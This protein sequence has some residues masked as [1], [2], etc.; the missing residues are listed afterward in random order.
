MSMEANEL[1][2]TRTPHRTRRPRAARA[3]DLCRAKKN[4]CDESY[5]C[6]Y[7]KNRNATCV[8]QGSQHTSWR[9]TAEYV[10]QLEDEVKRLSTTP[11][12]VPNV[13]SLVRFEQSPTGMDIDIAQHQTD[14]GPQPDTFVAAQGTSEE[15]ISEVNE[16]TA[17]VEF[18]GSSS[19]IALLSRVQRSGQ[20]SGDKEDGTHLVSNLH[21][22]TFQT[23]PVASHGD[24]PGAGSS[25][26]DYYPQC[27]SFIETFFSTIHY[28]HPILDKCEF[29]ER[30]E[31]LWSS[32]MN[33]ASLQVSGSFIALY[34]G[35]LSLGAIVSV[36]GEDPIDG[37]T[38]L[39]WSRKFFDLS[40]TCCHSLGLITNLEIAQC[41][42]VLVCT[43][44]GYYS[45]MLNPYSGKSLPERTKPTL[46]ERRPIN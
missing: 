29:L 19:S 9:Y 45:I 24:T 25:R 2:P 27:R 11:T 38:N 13:Q 32:S 6:T 22:A 30:C 10:K 4:K 23:T 8:Y 5:P 46:L 16:H 17:G 3:C 18:Y 33:G 31:S 1:N 12:H 44:Q 40:W 34:Y 21:N 43:N 42:F 14:H 20:Q 35:V 39:Q 26:V 37:L 28:I 41:L 7:C 15:E 36:R